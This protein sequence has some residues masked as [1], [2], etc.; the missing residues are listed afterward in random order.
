MQFLRVFLSNDR[1]V[2]QD[3]P[4]IYLFFLELTVIFQVLHFFAKEISSGQIL[5]ANFNGF[6]FV[7]VP[8][9]AKVTVRPSIHKS[10]F[11]AIYTEKLVPDRS[12]QTNGFLNLM[13]L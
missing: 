1:V 3:A 4:Y 6:R 9:K 5:F 13:F 10:S 12:R 11:F 7:L 8:S 2:P